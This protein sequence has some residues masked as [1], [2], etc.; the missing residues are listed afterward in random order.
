MLSAVTKE[1]MTKEEYYDEGMAEFAIAE[2]EKAIGCYRKAVELAPDY[3]DAWH[4]LGMAYL[5]AN[6][7]SEAI[8]DRKSTR[9][10][11][12]HRPLSRMPSSA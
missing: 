7:I 2:Y 4:A 8:E 6:K 1:P 3:F 12:S 11:S 9:L 5:R 10:N